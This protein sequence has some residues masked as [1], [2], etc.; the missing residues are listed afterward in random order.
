MRITHRLQLYLYAIYGRHLPDALILSHAVETWSGPSE[1]YCVS[2]LNCEHPRLFSTFRN[3]LLVDLVGIEP[4]SNMP[5][6]RVYVVLIGAS[7]CICSTDC[8]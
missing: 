4:T 7:D 5:Y 8:F 3:M 2:F 6:F 1:T